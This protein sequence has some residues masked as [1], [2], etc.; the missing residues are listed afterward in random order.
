MR[1]LRRA[2]WVSS[3]ALVAAACPAFAQFPTTSG[4]TITSTGQTTQ[5]TTTVPTQSATSTTIP[6]ASTTLPGATSNPAGNM[7]DS[8][9]QIENASQLQPPSKSNIRSS[10]SAANLLG[11]RYVSP[12][13]QG[14]NWTYV[15]NGAPGGFGTVTFPT[16]G[17][18]AG[19]RGTQAAGAQG[20]RGGAGSLADPGGQIVPLPKQI[21]YSSQVQFKLPPG[22]PVPQLLS[23]LRGSIDRVPTNM[24][25]NPT[26]VKVEVVNERNVILKGTVKD[27]EELR[28]VEGLVRLTPGVISIK[29]ELTVTK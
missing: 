8:Y 14:S 24:L 20:G 22:N 15:P 13:Y 27:E 29:N 28:L 19:G 21:A 16:T 10:L 18:T 7:A 9:N 12:L 4:Q 5:S 23:D 2:F 25:T 3:V 1:N 26:G 6:G 17:G 11:S